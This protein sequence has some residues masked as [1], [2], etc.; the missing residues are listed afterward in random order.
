[1]DIYKH[2]CTQIHT[3]KTTNAHIH[4]CTFLVLAGANIHTLTHIQTRI[5]AHTYSHAHMHKHRYAHTYT[6]AC[7]QS[8]IHMHMHTHIQAH[9]A[10]LISKC[11]L[12]LQ[13]LT[14]LNFVL[15]EESR[16]PP[17]LLC[18]FQD[19]PFPHILATIYIFL[20]LWFKRF[21]PLPYSISHIRI[22]SSVLPVNSR[23][24]STL[25]QM[26]RENQSPC[27][28]DDFMLINNNILNLIGRDYVVHSLLSIL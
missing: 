16:L 17:S 24:T 6:L 18:V 15:L 5:Y 14:S 19:F 12:K 9:Y 8:H 23:V 1:M 20:S 11:V 25:C 13:T 2:T 22:V 7:A 26:G 4:T 21:P 27:Y 3:L 28:S 10:A